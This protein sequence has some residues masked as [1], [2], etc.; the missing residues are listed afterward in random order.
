MRR[1]SRRSFLLAGAALLGAARAA[2]A[3]T[4]KRV[5]RVG[6]L[7]AT[8][9]PR[10]SEAFLRG[11]RELG[12]VEG[13]SV[14]VEMRSAGGQRDRL[15]V[16]AAEL[17]QSDVDVLVAGSTIGA[18]AA[19]A[20]TTTIP[21]VFAGSSD[22]VA[23]GLVANL[24]RPGGNVTGVSLAYGG[25]VAG[26]WVELLRELAPRVTR[27]ALLWTS[28]SP[29]S[30]QYVE[31]AEATASKLGV[32]TARHHATAPVEFDAALR[33]VAAGGAQGLVVM[34]S[35]F[36][37]AQRDALVAFAAKQRLPAM[38]FDEEFAEAGGLVSYGP[39]IAEAYRLAASYVDRILKGARPGELPVQQLNTY[40]LVIHRGTARS[41]GLAVRP[42]IAARSP[43]M[44]D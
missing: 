6:F 38:Y 24:A 25:G 12:Y 31:E 1:A 41:L 32:A 35:P 23:G 14:H 27:I 28:T 43:R 17:A 18:R 29:A 21:V 2:P 9:S 7:T 3:Q 20:A 5:P 33:E 42:S 22:P 34:P 44:V 11:M 8:T 30:T 16:L 40:E 39:S 4:G 37:V 26:K 36:W 15:P 19:K 13:R 10:R